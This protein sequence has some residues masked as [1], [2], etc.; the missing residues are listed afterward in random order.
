MA[1]KSTGISFN[2][3]ANVKKKKAKGRGKRYKRSPTQIEAWQRK[4]D[5]G[6]GGS[7]S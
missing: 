2:F 4:K 3:G 7:I 6:T 1:K 5:M